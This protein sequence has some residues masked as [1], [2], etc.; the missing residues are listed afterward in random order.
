MKKIILSFAVI[1]ATLFASCSKDSNEMIQESTNPANGS[2]VNLTFADEEPSTRA[3][4]STTATAEAWE[5]SLSDISMLVFDASGDIVV[6]REF[7]ASEL[8]AKKATFALP[9]VGSGDQCKF[10]VVANTSVNGVATEAALKA[11]L[12]S[13]PSLYN[14]TFAEVNSKAKR[15]GGFAMSGETSK[16]ITAGATDVAVTLKRTVA[17]VAVQVTKGAGFNSLYSGDVKVNSVVVSNSAS[18]SPIIKPT[19]PSTGAM[20]YTH[21]QATNVSGSN[22]QNLFYLFENGA[23]SN[24]VTLTI[25]ATYDR[26]GNFSTTTDQVP[27]TY[28]LGLDGSAGGAIARNGYYR[29]AASINGLSGSDASMTITVADWETTIT[30]SVGL[31]N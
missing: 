19:T 18:Q 14:G 22:Y 11:V 30:Q 6:S 31:G 29:V 16:T 12:E 24:R 21:T 9:G 2:V 1:S 20:S 5:K 17:K 7:N 23:T 4:F 28:S 27:V 3:F 10:Y 26:D 15:T 8:S 25:N 13:S